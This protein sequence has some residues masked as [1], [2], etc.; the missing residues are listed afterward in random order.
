MNSIKL[1]KDYYEILG[2]RKN[3]SDHE[4]KKAYRKLAMKW[5]PDHNRDNPEAED[6]FKEISEA[7]EVLKNPQMRQQYDHFSPYGQF[8]QR[9][10][11]VGS[12]IPRQGQQG[13]ANKSY[14]DFIMEL[15]KKMRESPYRQDHGFSYGFSGASGTEKSMFEEILIKKEKE[16]KDKKYQTYQNLED[17]IWNRCNNIKK[18]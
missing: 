8:R 16:D 18:E 14:Y 5:H 7:N 9:V 1:D 13:T 17:I 15:L 10:G 4:I 3:V 11:T 2:V 12:G 6:K